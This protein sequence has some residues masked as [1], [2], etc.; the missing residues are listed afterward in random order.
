MA[1]NTGEQPRR[2]AGTLSTP[3]D[4][5]ENKMATKYEIRPWTFVLYLEDDP[6]GN[7]PT[8]KGHFYDG[9]CKKMDIAGWQKT[10]MKGRSYISG[11]VS[12][13]YKPKESSASAYAAR[14]GDYVPGEDY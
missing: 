3:Q 6:T 2:S 10:S 5:L 13:E 8:H 9:E 1:Y 12:E 4:I 11:K 7:R 14:R